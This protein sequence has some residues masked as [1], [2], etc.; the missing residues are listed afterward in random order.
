M[1][2]VSRC[3]LRC[4]NLPIIG[5]NAVDGYVQNDIHI[6]CCLDDKKG[7]VCRD[8]A[9]SKM[10][11]WLVENNKNFYRGILGY[12]GGEL[13]NK[14]MNPIG[15]HKILPYDG[16]NCIQYTLCYHRRFNQVIHCPNR[17]SCKSRKSGNACVYRRD[18]IKLLV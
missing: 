2:M 4:H 5:Y 12:G 3:I 8:Y 17:G 1:R 13:D 7:G 18:P 16:G 11:G 10:S 14:I 6:V 9:A 15:N